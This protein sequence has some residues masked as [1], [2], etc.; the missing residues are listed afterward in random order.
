[1]FCSNANAKDKDKDWSWLLI[2][3]IYDTC[4]SGHDIISQ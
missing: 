3:F 2:F 1:M 4:V